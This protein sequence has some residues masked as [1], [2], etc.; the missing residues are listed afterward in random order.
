MQLSRVPQTGAIGFE[1]GEDRN[2][3]KKEKQEFVRAS[4]YLC[5]CVCV[6]EAYTVTSWEDEVKNG[7]KFR[8]AGATDGYRYAQAL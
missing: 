2:V 3:K 6:H 1:M 8:S 4:V 5:V 7:V